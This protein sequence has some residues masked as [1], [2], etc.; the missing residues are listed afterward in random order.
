MKSDINPFDSQETKAF[1]DEPEIVAMTQLVAAYQKNDI[2]RFEQILAANRATVMNDP[3]IREHIEELLSNIRT[4]VKLFMIILYSFAI[5]TFQV[6]LRLLKPYTRIRLAYLAEE[7]KIAQPEVVRLLVEIIHDRR[8]DLKI[9]QVNQTL[10]KVGDDK[11]LD[12]ARAQAM[13]K[14]CEQL[15]KLT[16]SL[17]EKCY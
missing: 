6:L 5:S 12:P 7:I 4:E 2:Q 13:S 8:P 3:F 1:K 11:N 15:E 9:D 17:V 16:K 10:V 14:V